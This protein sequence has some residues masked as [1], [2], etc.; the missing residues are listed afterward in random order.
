MYLGYFI[1]ATGRVLQRVSYTDADA[2]IQAPD[3]ATFYNAE[4]VDQAGYY[5]NTA[6]EALTLK[7]SIPVSADKT[8]LLANGTDTATVT[9]PTKDPNGN[10]IGVH[11][12]W[13]GDDLD[14]STGTLTVTAVEAGTYAVTFSG[15]NYLPVTLTFTVT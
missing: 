15:L 14:D 5:Y 13:I 3:G 9:L 2:T 1:D 11:I 7:P 4:T 8:N 10:A 6:A 12:N